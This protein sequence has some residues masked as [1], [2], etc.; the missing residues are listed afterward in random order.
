MGR[1]VEFANKE[2]CLLRS[3]L[4]GSQAQATTATPL[5]KPIASFSANRTFRFRRDPIR[6]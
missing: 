6:E 5:L 2:D 1:H 3:Q 4:I